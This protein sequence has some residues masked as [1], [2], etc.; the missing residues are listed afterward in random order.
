[1]KSFGSHELLV[2]NNSTTFSLTPKTETFIT[3]FGD[4]E[5]VVGLLEI[6][7]RTRVKR[8][9]YLHLLTDLFSESLGS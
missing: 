4:N 2:H 3:V 5:N 6:W 7:S 8:K 9:P 1:M